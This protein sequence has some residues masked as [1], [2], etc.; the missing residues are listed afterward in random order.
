MAEKPR[1]RKYF[2]TEFAEKLKKRGISAIASHQHFEYLE[3]INKEAVIS[4]VNDLKVDTVLITKLIDKQY[5]NVYKTEFAA[6]SRMYDYYSASE[7][8]VYST[9]EKSDMQVVLLETS[10]FDVGS[11][12]MIWT[13][14]SETFAVDYYEYK[15][16]TKSFI[17][18]MINNLSDNKLI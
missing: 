14:V 6:K 17:K 1:V 16:E 18:L 7:T 15:R 4:A 2:E 11:E 10:L 13:A 3:L 12:E 5:E 9:G 8:Q